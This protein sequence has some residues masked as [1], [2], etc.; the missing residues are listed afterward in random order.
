MNYVLFTCI[1]AEAVWREC[2]QYSGIQGRSLGVMFQFLAGQVNNDYLGEFCGIAWNIWN[3][4]NS[5]MWRNVRPSSQ[6]VYHQA[7]LLLEE[8][9]AANNILD[10][11]N[12]VI[13]NVKFPE[14]QALPSQHPSKEKK[15]VKTLVITTLTKLFNLPDFWEVSLDKIDETECWER[16]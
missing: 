4:R 12:P 14:A 7:L 15:R 9:R 6:I 13:N 11:S 10:L 1:S 5:Q 3:A 8:W 2:H 16:N